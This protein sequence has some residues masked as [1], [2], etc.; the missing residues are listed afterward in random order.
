MLEITDFDDDLIGSAPQNDILLSNVYEVHKGGFGLET[1]GIKTYF[2]NSTIRALKEDIKTFEKLTSQKSWPVSQIIQR[3]LDQVRVDKIASQYIARESNIRYFPPIIIAILPRD[4]SQGILPEFPLKDNNQST[5]YREQILRTSKYSSLNDLGR[6]KVLECD[7]LSNTDGL[8]VLSVSPNNI[9]LCW[10]T[11]T[12]YAIVIDGQHRFEALKRSTQEYEQSEAFKQDLVFIDVSDRARKKN[13]SP[14]EAVRRIFVDINYS[15]VPVSQSKRCLMDDKDLASLFVQTLLNDDDP[16]GE[17]GGSYLRPQLVDWHSDNLK[18]QLPH[19]TGVITLYQLMSD[20]I[21][22][23][24]NLV[25][26]EDLRNPT[27][28]KRWVSKLNT[29]FQIDKIAKDKMEYSRVKLLKNS[30]DEFKKEG[31]DDS[32]PNEDKEQL[33]QALFAFDYGVLDIAK[34]QFRDLYCR[35]I[36][37]FF[38]ELTHFN[39]AIGLLESLGAFDHENNLSRTLILSSKK[40]DSKQKISFEEAKSTMEERLNPDFYLLFTVLGQ[41]SLF[42]IFYKR[43]EASIISSPDQKK[44]EEATTKFIL[45]INHMIDLVT[46]HNDGQRIFGN[47]RIFGVGSRSKKNKYGSLSTNFWEGLIHKDGNIIWTRSG[48]DTFKSIIEYMIEF[49]SAYNGC[50]P[51]EFRRPALDKFRV[52]YAVRRISSRLKNEYNITED[53][54]LEARDIIKE[55]KNF[56]DDYLEKC[57]K[58]ANIHHADDVVS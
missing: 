38:N 3:D 6:K 20:V 56:L 42:D 50:A 30:L 45:E 54:D 41:R 48:V 4:S 24:S 40:Y 11:E 13:I 16:V 31:S 2:C 39:E 18:F 55:K 1:D 58:S 53:A 26:I 25:S 37:R 35:F 9:L 22:N 43:L 49:I 7:D 28:V 29:N 10:N 14:V 34:N 32:D 17:R 47:S 8:Y 36:V 46:R 33:S 52:N 51:S 27:K 57:L 5:E 21:L 12:C 23:Q 44:F 19:I 15:A